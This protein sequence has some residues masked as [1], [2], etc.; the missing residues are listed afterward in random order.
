MKKV[1]KICIIIFSLIFAIFS[2]FYFFQKSNPKSLEDFPA[3]AIPEDSFFANYFDDPAERSYWYEV[4]SDFSYK[5]QMSEKFYYIQDFCSGK[6]FIWYRECLLVELPKIAKFLIR[7]ESDRGNWEKF[8][9]GIRA[10]IANFEKFKI[11]DSLPSYNEFFSV[12]DEK[13]EEVKNNPE[14][15]WFTDLY[16]INLNIC[17]AIARLDDDLEK[18]SDGYYNPFYPHVWLSF[19][20]GQEVEIEKIFPN[21]H[22]KIVQ[23]WA[24]LTDYHG[25]PRWNPCWWRT[26]GPEIGHI[27]YSAQ[28]EK[29]DILFL[30]SGGGGGSGDFNY[31]VIFRER[32]SGEWEIV[33]DFPYGWIHPF[34]Y[35]YWDK[36]THDSKI[37]NIAKNHLIEPYNYL[38]ENEKYFRE[39][40]LELL[41]KMN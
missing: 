32:D 23:A 5:N 40:I 14:V 10:E 1:A 2:G 18:T 38:S 36:R 22:E 29:Y 25:K 26:F 15:H 7:D 21:Y 3:L 9:D 16:P 12:T 27:I 8:Y 4:W 20:R 30:V 31:Y 39:K 28:T 33:A 17:T 35:F 34:E 6:D 11:I 24:S 19:A 41:E 13:I 37:L